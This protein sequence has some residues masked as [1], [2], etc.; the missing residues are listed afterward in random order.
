MTLNIWEIS[1]YKENRPEFQRMIDDARSGKIDLIVVKSVSR[2]IQSELSRRFDGI[3]F[4]VYDTSDRTL[5]RG[6]KVCVSGQLNLPG[7]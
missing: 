2:F 1:G 6:R 5:A 3:K 4:V 7:F